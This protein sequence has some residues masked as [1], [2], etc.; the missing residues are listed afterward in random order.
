MQRLRTASRRHP[1]K[2]QP[3]DVS[4]SIAL[5][6]VERIDE[7]RPLKIRIIE[8]IQRKIAQMPSIPM[9]CAAVNPKGVW[10]S[11]VGIRA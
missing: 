11:E 7:F 1:I 8:N 10:S 9:L 5:D 3:T 6:P 4:P 2:A